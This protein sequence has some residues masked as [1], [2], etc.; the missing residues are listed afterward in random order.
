[1]KTTKVTETETTRVTETIET[2]D[3]DGQPHPPAHLGWYG[4]FP[5]SVFPMIRNNASG[6]YRPPASGFVGPC[7]NGN[8]PVFCNDTNQDF[9]QQGVPTKLKCELSEVKLSTA[10]DIMVTFVLVPPF[11]DDKLLAPMD[12]IGMRQIVAISDNR[13]ESHGFLQLSA[14]AVN[15]VGY[16]LAEQ[17]IPE[18]KW[19][20]CK[21]YRECGD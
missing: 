1:M 5:S 11:P 7:Q 13:K 17:N 12:S 6:P 2:S 8:D 19:M 15:M 16:A 20:Y 3:T 10:Y 4:A 14:E 9:G 21:L 18:G